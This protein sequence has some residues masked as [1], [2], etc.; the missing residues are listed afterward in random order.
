[1][2][3]HSSTPR[4]VP[5]YPGMTFQESLHYATQEHQM[6]NTYK[7]E[8][9]EL[10][11]K[12]TYSLELA[13]LYTKMGECAMGLWDWKEAAEHLTQALHLYRA[14]FQE[15]TG[16]AGDF[17]APLHRDLARCYEAQVLDANTPQVDLRLKTISHCKQY[18][19]HD[20]LSY[21]AELKTDSALE[22]RH[23]INILLGKSLNALGLTQ[24][25]L[26]AFLEISKSGLENIDPQ[27]FIE[28]TLG[29]AEA[30]YLEGNHT[31]ALESVHMAIQTA[32]AG[33]YTDQLARAYL[34][35]EKIEQAHSR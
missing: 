35:E 1:M 28:M 7:E 4:T 34:L 20:I 9:A 21:P 30:D 12:H 24:Q 19:L 29:V 2:A 33:G 14:H 27:I 18:L 10:E 23:S 25:A 22:E 11:K 5:N 13:K 31:T 8:A 3:N 17:L 6:L 16:A 26:L 32:Q 15:L